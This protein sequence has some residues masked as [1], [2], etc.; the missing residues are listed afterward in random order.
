MQYAQVDYSPE[1]VAPRVRPGSFFTSLQCTPLPTA[2]RFCSRV[3]GRGALPACSE[4][5]LGREHRDAE[6]NG[7]KGR[8]DGWVRGHSS[9]GLQSILIADS[10]T[11]ATATCGTLKLVLSRRLIA[12]VYNV[13]VH[14]QSKRSIKQEAVAVAVP[15]P[16]SLRIVLFSFPRKLAPWISHKSHERRGARCKTP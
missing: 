2:D 14:T 15:A 5:T 16:R 4:A 13:D 1:L 6:K 8:W 9:F 7:S 11:R 12:H 3:K 10:D